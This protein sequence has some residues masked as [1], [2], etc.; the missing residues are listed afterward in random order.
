MWDLRAEGWRGAG[1]RAGTSLWGAAALGVD[2]VFA[3]LRRKPSRPLPPCHPPPG[4]NL[5]LPVY[6]CAPCSPVACPRPSS[7]LCGCR[8]VTVAAAATQ[9]H[10]HFSY[11]CCVLCPLLCVLAC[12]ASLRRCRYRLAGAGARARA[13]RPGP[14]P[15]PASPAHQPHGAAAADAWPA[16]GGCSCSRAARPAAGAYGGPQDDGGGGRGEE[17]GGGEGAHIVRVAWHGGW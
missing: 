14:R 2:L 9:Q 5:C 16:G 1:V 7:S 3:R 11:C 13:R 17:A 6:S 15:G 4:A 10:H 8:R 12:C